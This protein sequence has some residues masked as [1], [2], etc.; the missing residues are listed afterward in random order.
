M[1]NIAK[2][3]LF[4]SGRSQAVR[5]P[6]AMRFPEGTR[7]VILQ[8]AGQSLIISPAGSS[9]DSFFALEKLDEDFMPKRN[10]GS[11]QEREEI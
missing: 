11:F 1:A 5:I 7:E 10:Q 3:S 2:S 4:M 9:W 8:R 6:A